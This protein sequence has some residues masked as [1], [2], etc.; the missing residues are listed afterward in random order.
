MFAVVLRGVMWKNQSIT[1]A[2]YTHC[3]NTV[4]TMFPGT[5]TVLTEN[6]IGGI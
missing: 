1:V 3:F 2:E 4:N 5:E 6:S